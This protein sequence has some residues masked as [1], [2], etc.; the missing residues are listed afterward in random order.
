[1]VSTRRT[2]PAFRRSLER[3]CA[4]LNRAIVCVRYEESDH[5][6]FMCLVFACKQ[7][8]HA[9]AVL[10][11][12]S[13]PDCALVV[14][15]MLEG[16]CQLKWALASP[17]D[18]PRRWRA[19]ALVADWRAA[20]RLEAEG[21]APVGLDVAARRAS[22]HPFE[23]LFLTRKAKN[24]ARIGRP[25]PEDPFC[26]TWYGTS[27]KTIFEA[28][29]AEPHYNWSYGAFSDW[30]HWSPSGVGAALRRRGR[31]VRWTSVSRD[32]DAGALTVAFQCVVETA[33][34]AESVLRLGIAAEL[35]EHLASF[36]LIARAE[37]ARRD[38]RLARR[39]R[40][41]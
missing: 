13:H 30:H 39:S 2:F 3:L 7:L 19:F 40:S 25:L 27:L 1:M 14:R 28:V 32:S 17:E 8:D 41:T 24:L 11:L 34:A 29:K 6:A 12:G 16:L 33:Q 35:Q 23:Q 26:E 20:R 10:L 37:K 4:T 31:S 9:R 15:S 22:I 36:L 18:R 21:I 38:A 5:S